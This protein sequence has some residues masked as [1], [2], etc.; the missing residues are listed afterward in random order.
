MGSILCALQPN[1]NVSIDF[2]VLI[3]GFIPRAESYSHLFQPNSIKNLASLHIYGVNDILIDHDRTIKLAGSFENSI[4][5]SHPGGH[6]TPNA[7]PKTIIKQFLIE[8]QERLFNKQN[9][10]INNDIDQ[11]KPLITFE[12]K[13][14]AT[15][16]NHQKRMSTVPATERKHN[17]LPIIPIGLSKP[18][19]PL[20]IETMIDNIDEYLLDDIILLI[21]C[22]RTTF[23]NSELKED[24]QKDNN[25]SLFFRHWILLYLK[26]PN[27]L[28]TSY[29]NLFLK[30]GGWS[31]LKTLYVMVCHMENEFQN[32]KILLDN[33]KA[34][35]IKQVGDQLKHDSLIILNQPDESA[36][37]KEQ[38]NS[39]KNEEWIS[40]CAK[41]APRLSNNRTKPTTSKYSSYI[42]L[43]SSNTNFSCFSYGKRYCQIYVSDCRF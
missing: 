42:S 1:G 40:N 7:W 41:E 34:V 18:L 32:E 24:K 26:R 28:L 39:I 9:R 25:I 43:T 6:Y 20:N 13:L 31:D 3:S 30:Y 21:W 19:N 5:L 12:E 10:S 27:E 17:K 33:L 22:E 11:C 16:S 2:S 4:V 8:Q 15:I 35:C 38:E 14:I 23:Y 37:D 36:N 29:F